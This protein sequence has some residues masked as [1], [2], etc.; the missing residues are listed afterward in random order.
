MMRQ[1]Y[2]VY[3]LFYL[4]KLKMFLYAPLFP[5]DIKL[6]LMSEFYDGLMFTSIFIEFAKINVRGFY[7]LYSNLEIR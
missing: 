5:C 2:G 4:L 1:I 3:V 7:L 6:T